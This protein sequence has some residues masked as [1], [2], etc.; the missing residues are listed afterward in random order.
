MKCFCS[1]LNGGLNILLITNGAP[2]EFGLRNKDVKNMCKNMGPLYVF[3]LTRK[4]NNA[5]T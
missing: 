4:K 2:V 3:G 1:T 5:F